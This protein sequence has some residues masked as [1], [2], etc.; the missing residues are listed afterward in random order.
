[1][2]NQVICSIGSKSEHRAEIIAA[3]G[4][5]GAVEHA[6][7]SYDERCIWALPVN[8]ISLKLVKD[9]V[10]TAVAEYS[11]N[12]A[13]RCMSSFIGC[14]IQRTVQSLY[15]GSLGMLAISMPATKTV[16]NGIVRP[17]GRDSENSPKI[18]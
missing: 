14:P 11:E 1:M 15:E 17:V 16:D 18:V 2:Q 13:G 8:I 6:I 7:L 3:A 9:L 5:R 4:V 10:A 12:S